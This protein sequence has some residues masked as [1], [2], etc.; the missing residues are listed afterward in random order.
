[1]HS[2]SFLGTVAA[3]CI[4]QLWPVPRDARG[5]QLPNTHSPTF[6]SPSLSS[7]P[8]STTVPSAA[9][10]LL[11]IYSINGTSALPMNDYPRPS[12]QSS[13]PLM[14]KH[15]LGPRSKLSSTPVT[16]KTKPG[17]NPSLEAKVRTI[18]PYNILPPSNA[19]ECS[20]LLSRSRP[21]GVQDEQRF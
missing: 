13:S 20:S 9:T 21:P 11:F 12:N 10:W 8:P 17:G 2:I 1:M 16:S 15:G 4:S 6:T 3:G 14:P 19:L 5:P 7:S 18:R